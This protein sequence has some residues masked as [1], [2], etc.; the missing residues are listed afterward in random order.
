MTRMCR[1]RHT[2]IRNSDFCVAQYNSGSRSTTIVFLCSLKKELGT[3]PSGVWGK[4][5]FMF[6]A[7]MESAQIWKKRYD[8]EYLSPN[9]FSTAST[10]ILNVGDTETVRKPYE[11]SYEPAWS[12]PNG[13]LS[14]VKRPQL[15][16]SCTITIDAASRST[17]QKNSTNTST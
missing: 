15:S 13:I 1:F 16:Y 11:I 12:R 6:P 2:G 7:K 5:F 8:L 9:P 14:L 17:L 10:K 4:L 3:V